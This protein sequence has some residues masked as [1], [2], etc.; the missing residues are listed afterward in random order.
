MDGDMEYAD[1]VCR[2]FRTNKN[3]HFQVCLPMIGWI[4]FYICNTKLKGLNTYF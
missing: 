2:Q 3:Y 1:T 4:F